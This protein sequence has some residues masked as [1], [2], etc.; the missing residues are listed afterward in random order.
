[1]ALGASDYVTLAAVRAEGITSTMVSDERV[2]S[3]ARMSA[4]AVDAFTRCWFYDR[5]YGGGSELYIDG[6][7]N[8]VLHLPAP[9]I[10]I[11]QIAIDYRGDRTFEEVQATTY[12]AYDSPEDVRNP[13]VVRIDGDPSPLKLGSYDAKWPRGRRNIRLRCHLGWLEDAATPIAITRAVI[14]MIAHEKDLI[15]SDLA[16]ESRARRK[17]RVTSMTT[18]NRS[19]SFADAVMAGGLTGDEIVD[20]TLLR[21]RRAIL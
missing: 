11:E 21:Y 7:G 18:H 19:I 4:R 15:G 17:G 8:E 1:M 14:R 12:V 20:G 9:I 5:T 6:S 16:A 13:K 3:I 2:E 10:S